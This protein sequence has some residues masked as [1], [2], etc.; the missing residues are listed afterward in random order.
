[1]AITRSS[2]VRARS[3]RRN[4]PSLKAEILAAMISHFQWSGHSDTILKEPEI[5]REAMQ[6]LTNDGELWEQ[7][8]KLSNVVD[9]LKKIK[10]RL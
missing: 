4:R 1:M 7:L 8:A 10:E 6:D 2:R 3:R 5:I 9:G